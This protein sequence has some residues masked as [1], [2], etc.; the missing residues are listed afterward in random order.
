M[1]IY[2]KWTPDKIDVTVDLNYKDSPASVTTTVDAGSSVESVVGKDSPSR[3]G[4]DFTGWYTDSACKTPIAKSIKLYDNTTLYAGWAER[5]VGYVV[6]YLDEATGTPLLPPKSGEGRVGA[7]VY[8]YAETVPMYRVENGML[9]IT[10]DEQATKNVITFEYASLETEVEYTVYY[11]RNV[12]DTWEDLLDPVTAKTTATRVVAKAKAIAGYYP[13][14][15]SQML[16]LG[17]G[18]KD[19][20]IHFE[21][22]AYRSVDYSIKHYHQN[23]EGEYVEVVEATDT[24]EAAI[25]ETLKTTRRD[26][27]THKLAYSLPEDFKNS[28]HHTVTKADADA[29]K[30]LEFG[31]YYR[32]L[33]DVP[34]SKT[35]IDGNDIEGIRPEE[36]SVTIA[37]P[38]GVTP[39]VSQ[40]ITITAGNKWT[41]AFEKLPVFDDDGQKIAYKLTEQSIDGYILDEITAENGGFAIVNR[42]GQQETQWQATKVW[43]DGGNRHDTR[44]ED[45][46]DQAA[47][48][49]LTADGQPADNVGALDFV[50]A[51]NEWTYTWTGL[52]KYEI[53]G[54]AYREIVYSSTEPQTP[55]GYTQ[56]ATADGSTITNTLKQE[57][58]T[59]TAS[60]TW[61][62]EN[63]IDGTRPT[64][65]QLTL[66]GNGSAVSDVSPTVK[67]EGNTWTYTWTGLPKYETSNFATID[68]TVDEL[69]VP[70]GYV[71]SVNGLNIT[72]THEPVLTRDVVATKV[73]VDSG[74]SLRPN[75]LTLTLYADGTAVSKAPVVNATGNSWT[76]TWQDMPIYVEG[77][78]GKQVV[79]TVDELN[80]PSNY[81]KSVSGLTVTNTLTQSETVTVT[82]SKVWVDGGDALGMR[83]SDV[84]I[85]LYANGSAVSAAPNSTAKNG[86]TWTYTWRDMPKSDAGRNKQEIH[87]TADEVSVPSGYTKS[88]SGLTITNTLSQVNDV[89][90]TARKVWADDNNAAGQRPDDLKLTLLGNGALVNATATV[91]GKSGN[92]WTYTWSGLPRYNMSGDFSEIKYT[93]DEMSVPDGYR[94]SI[95]ADGLTVTNTIRTITVYFVDW[96]GDILKTEVVGY[97]G[98]ATPPQNPER[99]GWLF[100][101]WNGNWTNVTHDEWVFAQYGRDDRYEMLIDEDIPLAGGYVTNVGDCYD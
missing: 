31:L 35:W 36:I 25:A 1:F 26:D 89:T 16:V 30:L 13:L 12:G 95:S 98:S 73:W 80:V 7:A 91:T 24:G 43:L 48:I 39:A 49:V 29:G 79:Y 81:E 38:D 46:Q 82:I 27:A 28:L 84:D 61:V 77:G 96:D 69:S 92:V 64:S 20:V 76:Y 72:N 99:E 2:V 90:V 75:G 54:D 9:G 60:K 86:N 83:P 47:L 19:N 93:V 52:P 14:Q 59:V 97:L 68:Y 37:T 40:S 42:L 18:A 57:T 85:R 33:A 100:S 50:K 62:D 67:A 53:D 58:V 71:K 94:K 66:L 21:Y 6:R 55:Q 74:S 87:Y 11:G 32:L 56:S 44:P 34:V 3:G 70:S 10:L 65:L 63:N 4:Y 88:V 51:E 23:A 8:E 45:E 101:G 41:G 15:N 22:E 5:R 17:G 78:E